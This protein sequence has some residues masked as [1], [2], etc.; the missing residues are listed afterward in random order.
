MHSRQ[1]KT[2]TMLKLFW[3]DQSVF[4]LFLCKVSDECRA[5]APS[6]KRRVAGDQY[7]NITTLAATT[8]AANER[9]AGRGHVI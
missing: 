5:A 1:F 3:V 6:N 8:A 7:S 4:F 9:G 2:K